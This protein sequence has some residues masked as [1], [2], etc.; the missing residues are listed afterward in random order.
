MNPGESTL[1]TCAD[2]VADTYHAN[3]DRPY[4]GTTGAP[5]PRPGALQLVFADL[6]T[7]AKGDD[8]KAYHRFR[9]MLVARGVPA[10]QVQFA[11]EHAATAASK[12][13]F[14]AACRDG[15]VAVAVSST[16]KRGMGTNVQD[17]MVA[18]RHLDCQWRPSDIEQ[19]EGGIMRQ[20]NQKPEVTIS[21]YVPPSSRSASTA[22]RR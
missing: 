22:G 10:E 19:R 8:T 5:N 4:R 6:G 11:Y 14:F 2:Q 20:G 1:A 7:P 18:M 15:R 9:Q 3:K 21:A 13:R 16:V 17:R 12:E